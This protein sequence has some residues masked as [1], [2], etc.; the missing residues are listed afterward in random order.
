MRNL[1]VGLVLN[2]YNGIKAQ[3]Q[4]WNQERDQEEELVMGGATFEFENFDGTSDFFLWKQKMRT[5]LMQ[6]KV[7]KLLS[8]NLIC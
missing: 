6:Q 3:V 8:K 7:D 2:S 4:I 5:V 1:G